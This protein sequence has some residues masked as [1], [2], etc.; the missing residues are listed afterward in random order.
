MCYFGCMKIASSCVFAF[1]LMFTAL[2]ASDPYSSLSQS[3]KELLK[4]Q[5]ERW[6]HDQIKHDWA[7]LWEIQDQTPELKNDLLLGERDAPDMDR[8]RYVQAMRATIGS[9]YPEIKAFKLNEIQRENGGFRVEGCARLQRENWKQ[10][11]VTSVHARIVNNKLVF[12]LPDL[13]PDPCKL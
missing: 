10:T 9:G 5:V 12:G 8:N 11:S 4:P 2:P 7:D 13:T 6:I 3:E 1:V